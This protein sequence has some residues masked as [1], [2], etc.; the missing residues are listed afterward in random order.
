MREHEHGDGVRDEHHEH[1]DG[2]AVEEHWDAAV[3]ENTGMR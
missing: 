3:K 2:V 1:G